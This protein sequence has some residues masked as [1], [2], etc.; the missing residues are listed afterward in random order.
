MFGQFV[1]VIDY[2]IAGAIFVGNML[3][4]LIYRFDLHFSLNTFYLLQIRPF[5]METFSFWFRLTDDMCLGLGSYANYEGG[6]IK[7]SLWGKLWRLGSMVMQVASK[8]CLLKFPKFSEELQ[9]FLKCLYQMWMTCC[10]TFGLL[11]RN[12]LDLLF[13][14]VAVLVP[15]AGHAVNS[16]HLHMHW[17]TQSQHKHCN[18]IS[19]H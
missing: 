4:T 17:K 16:P 9:L 18:N 14:I 19:M 5:V 13:K 7:T 2:D 12:S 6:S 3:C 10:P 1:I 8:S 15:E 11:G